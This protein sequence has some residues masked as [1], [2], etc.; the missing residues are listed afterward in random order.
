MT[1]T[2]NLEH[3]HLVK[4]HVHFL[5]NGLPQ[6]PN[7]I[8]YLEMATALEQLAGEYRAIAANQPQSSSLQFWAKNPIE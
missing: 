1:T 3:V 4:H 6:P 5:L 7:P 2:L 8:S